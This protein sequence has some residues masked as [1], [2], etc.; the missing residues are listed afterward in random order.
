MMTAEQLKASILQLAMEGKLVEQR[1]EEG[2]AREILPHLK[3]DKKIGITEAPFDIPE[4]W[5]WIP[6]GWLGE[7]NDTDSFCDGPF[8]SN[9]KSIHQISIPEVRIIQLSNIGE[10]GWKN[11]NVKYTS[12]KHLEEVI[13][14]CEV[15]PGD[16]VIAK[17]MPAGRTIEVPDLG[18]RMTLGSDAMKFVPNSYLDKQYLLLAMHSNA[19]LDQVYANAHGITR[20]RTTLKGIKSYMIPIPPI[21]EQKRI[22]NKINKI[23]PYIRHYEEFSQALEKLN[24]EFPDQ[25]KKSILQMAVEGK[26][27][28]QRPEEGTGEELF[29]KIQEEKAKL[30]K[31]GKI[32]KQ[33]SLADITDEEK[34]FDIP[35][36]W[37]WVRLGDII[38]DTEAGKSPQCSNKPSKADEWGVI[39]TTAIQDGYFLA[40]E[41]KV[42]PVNFPVQAHQVVHEGDLL[43]TRAGPKNRTGVVCVVD[44]EPSKLILSDK[45]VRIK[46]LDKL[47]NPYYLMAMLA[48]PKIQDEVIASMSGM[49]ASQVNISQNKMKE[50]FIPLPPITEQNRIVARLNQVLPDIKLLTI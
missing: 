20:V 46:Y 38:V 22:V 7:T 33:K 44:I 49:A 29:R 27:V 21:P 2:S 11:D 13:P 12:Y 48:S 30:I 36:S 4:S 17:M 9:L 40:S 31:E 19:L 10:D 45:T 37:K 34:P 25:V 1:P 3:V 41:N 42:L 6:I 16:F 32:K 15:H 39:K 35:E 18:T 24:K 47:T 14:R 50:Y 26:L 23:L 5:L 43:I 8:G 28:E